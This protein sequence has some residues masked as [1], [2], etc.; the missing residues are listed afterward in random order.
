[1]LETAAGFALLS[2]LSP[3]AVLVG[4][5]YLGSA[6]PRRTTLL[7]LAGA[8][9]TTV[10]IGIIVLVALRSGGLSLPTNRVAAVRPAAG[11]GRGGAG[12]RPVHDAVASPSRPTRPRRRSPAWSAGRCPGPSRYSR[13]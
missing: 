3:T 12:R 8:L 9:T 1:M 7:Y 10:I 2:A 11:A 13:S 6:S 4:A 5:V